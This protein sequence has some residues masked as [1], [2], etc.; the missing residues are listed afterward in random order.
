MS[1]SGFCSSASSVKLQLSSS[2]SVSALLLRRCFVASSWNCH[3][4]SSAPIVL[5]FSRSTIHSCVGS[6]EMSRVLCT[7]SLSTRLRGSFP[8]FEQ[9]QN[10]RGRADFQRGRERAHVGIAD[11]QMQPPIFAIIGQR[12]VARVDDG[13]IELHPLIDVVDDVIGA[14]AQLKIDRR[15]PVAAV[16]NR[17]RA[18]WPAPPGRRR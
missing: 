1:D 16:R 2:Q 7:A 5:P 13:A 15:L 8:I 9:R 4:T 3:C 6:R 11:E 18:G 10:A 12:L 14:L 17:T